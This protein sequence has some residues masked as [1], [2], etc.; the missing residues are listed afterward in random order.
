MLRHH[1]AAAQRLRPQVH[2]GL[3]WPDRARLALLAGMRLIV[4]PGTIVS[5]AY[6]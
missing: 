6:S 5:G 1:L 2:A 3:T 4:T